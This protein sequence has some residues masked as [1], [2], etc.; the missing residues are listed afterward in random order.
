LLKQTVVKEK[1]LVWLTTFCFKEEKKRNTKQEDNK[2]T[3]ICFKEEKKHKV[4][5]NSVVSC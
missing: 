5:S 1:V 2:K 3:T 4:T